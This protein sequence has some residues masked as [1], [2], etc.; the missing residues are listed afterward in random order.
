MAKRHWQRWSL[1]IRDQSQP[2]HPGIANQTAESVSTNGRGA[3][4]KGYSSNG[5]VAA[6]TEEH[7]RGQ[8]LFAGHYSLLYY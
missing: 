1:A 3:Y 4:P 2:P 5:A 7:F 6:V 8:G